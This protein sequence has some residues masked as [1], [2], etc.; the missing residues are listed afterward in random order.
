MDRTRTRGVEIFYLTSWRPGDSDF[1]D[2]VLFNLHGVCT[3]ILLRQFRQRATISLHFWFEVDDLAPGSH[4]CQWNGFWPNHEITN[5]TASYNVFETKLR[6]KL[7]IIG[8]RNH[9]GFVDL[10][11]KFQRAKLVL[12]A[13]YFLC[14]EGGLSRSLSFLTS[15]LPGNIDLCKTWKPQNLEIAPKFLQKCS[16]NRKKGIN[17]HR[18]LLHYILQLMRISRILIIRMK[19]EIDPNI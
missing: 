12:R 6:G 19:F 16:P 13:T 18:P 4:I 3:A 17:M 9:D 8:C 10:G 14:V 15:Y 5:N 7:Q 1:Q 11:L 2:C